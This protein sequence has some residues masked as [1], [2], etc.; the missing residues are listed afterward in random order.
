MKIKVTFCMQR[1]ADGPYYPIE[2]TYE[3]STKN[4]ALHMSRKRLSEEL[5]ITNAILVDYRVEEVKT[6]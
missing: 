6:K 4:E 3:N 1:F 2:Y 5:D